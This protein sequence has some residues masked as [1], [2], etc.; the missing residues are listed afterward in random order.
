MATV[1]AVLLLSVLSCGKAEEKTKLMNGIVNGTVDLEPGIPILERYQQIK[2]FYNHTQQILKKQKGK[3]VHYNNEY[4]KNKT[5]LFENGTLRIVRLRK[6]DSSK[7]KII[8]EDEKGLEIPIMIQ[9]NIY[10]P[11]PKPRLNVTSLKKT[12]GGCSVT[13]KCS[14]SI[15]DVTYTWYK[16][17]KKCSYSELN[18]DLVLSLTSESNIMYNC[19]VCNSASCNTESIY[20]RGDCQWQDRNTASSTFRLAADSAVTLGILLLLH[21]LL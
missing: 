21:N 10:A 3:S 7:Y 19:T 2:W 11:V 15:P 12:K 4:F 8:V 20:Y 18:G 1:L 9:L 17:D 5:K 6:E 13:L 14:V 16:D